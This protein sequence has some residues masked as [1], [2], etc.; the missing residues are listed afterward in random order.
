MRRKTWTVT[1]EAVYV[2]MTYEEW[3]APLYEFA[4]P[5]MESLFL[6]DPYVLG[7]LEELFAMPVV[8]VEDAV[9][10]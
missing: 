2:E 6:D 3:L 1:C 8:V 9:L 5:V 7:M 4:L 10:S